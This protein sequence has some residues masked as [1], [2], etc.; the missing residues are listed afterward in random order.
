MPR[1]RY[2]TVPTAWTDSVEHRRKIADVANGLLQGNSN[3]H[4]EVTLRTV[5]T[6]TELASEIIG[7]Q[8][9]AYLAA[10]TPGAAAA[11]PLIWQEVQVGKVILH[12]DASADA[13][14]RFGV[15]LVG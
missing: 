9:F 1:R 12:H 8:T 3:N 15:L 7:S 14:R 13:D 2:Q 6:T 10:L 5:E 4:Y 11:L